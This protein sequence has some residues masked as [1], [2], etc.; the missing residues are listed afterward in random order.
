MKYLDLRITADK[1]PD[2]LGRTDGLSFLCNTILIIP[3]TLSNS[4]NTSQCYANWWHME[5]HVNLSI[6]YT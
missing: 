1:V 5:M 2:V 6:N 4:H 3:T